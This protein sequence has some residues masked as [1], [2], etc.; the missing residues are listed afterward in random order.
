MV[1]PGKHRSIRLEF[2]DLPISPINGLPIVYGTPEEPAVIRGN[3]VT[4]A[5]YDFKGIDIQVRYVASAAVKFPIASGA[6]VERTDIFSE[7]T[8]GMTLQDSDRPPGKPFLIKAGVHSLPFAFTVQSRIPSSFKTEFSTVQF[9]L[10]ASVTRGTWS[11]DLSVSS[12]VNV[13]NSLIPASVGVEKDSAIAAVTN[14]Y[15]QQASGLGFE[16]AHLVRSTGIWSKIQPFE[17]LYRHQTVYWGQK[18]PVTIRVFPPLSQGYVAGLMNAGS[19]IVQIDEIKMVLEHRMSMRGQNPNTQTRHLVRDVFHQNVAGQWPSLTPAEIW[20][21]DL[22][23]EIPG[24]E[25]LTPSVNNACLLIVFEV[26]FFIS[27]TTASGQ[28]VKLVPYA[29]LEVTAPRPPGDPMPA[30]SEV[31]AEH[32]R[33]VDNFTKVPI[34]DYSGITLNMGTSLSA[35]PVHCTF[36]IPATVPN[37]GRLALEAPPVVVV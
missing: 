4:E 21:T 35:P 26:Q 32:K 7:L 14:Q 27:C 19:P 36:N 29:P 24:L 25:D 33:Y 31:M 23:V 5:D 9:E 13:V 8:R 2:P 10:H 11:K 1:K 6:T 34:D 28:K 22:V 12:A 3:F 17:V 20:S 16:I 15:R 37:G 18:M 30:L